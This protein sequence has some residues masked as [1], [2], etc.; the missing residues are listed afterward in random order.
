MGKLFE[1]F[2]LTTTAHDFSAVVM[3]VTSNCGT[4]KQV[5]VCVC[6]CV[7]ICVCVFSSQVWAW[8]QF[9]VVLV[10][11]LS[12]KIHDSKDS[13]LHQVQSR[14]R[15]TASLY[16]RVLGQEDIYCETRDSLSLLRASS[17][18]F[19]T[20]LS[21]PCFFLLCFQFDTT[22]GEIVQEYDRHLGAVNTV[23]FVDENRRFVTTSDDKSIRVWEW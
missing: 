5:C 4:L 6:V 23:T 8:G 11:R 15:Q 17:L 22:N 2:A 3:I 16:C 1:T 13:L 19:L 18:S 20:P 21:S 7:C 9:N 12:W 14:R 10:R